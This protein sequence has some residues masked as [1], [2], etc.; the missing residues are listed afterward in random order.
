MIMTIVG[1]VLIFFRERA[2]VLELYRLGVVWRR[3]GLFQS[4]IGWRML[5]EMIVFSIHTPIFVDVNFSI[6]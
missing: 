1:C 6:K 3:S 5:I 2:K 4:G